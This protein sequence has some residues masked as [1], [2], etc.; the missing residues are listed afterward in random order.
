[1]T[2]ITNMSHISNCFKQKIVNFSELTFPNLDKLRKS[3][4]T[5]IKNDLNKK[6]HRR[7][8]LND[9]Y[10]DYLKI[11][12]YGDLDYVTNLLFDIFKYLINTKHLILNN[13]FDVFSDKF[14]FIINNSKTIFLRNYEL[15][16]L[17]KEHLHFI[18]GI[19]WNSLNSNFKDILLDIHYSNNF[20]RYNIKIFEDMLKSK[21]KDIISDTNISNDNSLLTNQLNNDSKDDEWEEIKPKKRK[22]KRKVSSDL[23]KVKESSSVN[24]SN[25]V[26]IPDEYKINNFINKNVIIKLENELK[27]KQYGLMNELSDSF[28]QNLDTYPDYMHDEFISDDEYSDVSDDEDDDDGNYIIE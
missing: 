8:S 27:S 26:K 16:K 7:K 19:Y 6:S 12:K 4:E 14:A 2:T 22:D 13:K 23:T 3:T 15:F 25:D 11:E 21:G 18:T 17:I 1:M 24:K 5:V 28:I 9:F 10:S 20:Y